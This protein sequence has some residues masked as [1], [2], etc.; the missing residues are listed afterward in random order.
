MVVFGIGS[1]SLHGRLAMVTEPTVRAQSGR[2]Y[3]AVDPRSLPDTLDPLPDGMYQNPHFFDAA[4]MLR[5][6]FSS[7][8]DVFVEGNTIVCYNPDNLN[9]R[10]LPDC[11][12]AFG[13]APAAIYE[14]NG[15]LIWEVGKAPDF[16]LE[17]ASVST[18]RRDMTVKRDLHAE[19]GVREYWRFDPSG[20][21][22]YGKPLTGEQLIDGGYAP[23]ALS[24]NDDGLQCGY[25]PVLGL[26]LC[27][28][29]DRLLF[30]NPIKG[31]YLRT[32]REA[33][34]RVRDLEEELRRLRP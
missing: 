10:V 31:E 7:A 33:E 21:D 26:S 34:A 9:D 11:Y 28:G 16:V 18:A 27:A 19:I 32:L 6:H 23:I 29:N 1:F 14:Q 22:F 12:V 30:H 24:D 17:I 25:S 4:S 8:P 5:A 13:V 2:R 3:P 15:Y 20:G